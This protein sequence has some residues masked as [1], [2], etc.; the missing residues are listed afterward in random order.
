MT[1]WTWLAVV[2]LG[3]VSGCSLLSPEPDPS[4]FFVLTATTPGE[5]SPTTRGDLVV[6]VGPTSIP[7]YL[8]RNEIVTRISP[9]ELRY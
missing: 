6:G 4:R 7:G 2:M 8:D 1:M 5:A 9:D 3:L